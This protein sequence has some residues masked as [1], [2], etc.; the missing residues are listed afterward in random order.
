M[1][2]EL[3]IA[4]QIARLFQQNRAVVWELVEAPVP[5]RRHD[6]AIVDTTGRAVVYAR[7]TAA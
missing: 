4:E 2:P 7:P 1:E 3:V 5:A 6:V